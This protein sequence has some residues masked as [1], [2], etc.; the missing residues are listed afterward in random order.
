MGASI[1]EFKAHLSLHLSR[2]RSGE[3]ITITDRGTPVAMVVPM[4]AD[5]T[6]ERFVTEG[7]VTPA[8]LVS[9]DAKLLSAW[10]SAGVSTAAISPPSPN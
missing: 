1:R 5:T 4:G 9:G 6:R 2:V 10:H 7:K 3:T 8:V